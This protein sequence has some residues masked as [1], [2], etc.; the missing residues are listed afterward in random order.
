VTHT[1]R[2]LAAL[3]VVSAVGFAA[4]GDGGEKKEEAADYAWGTPER[5]DA[6]GGAREPVLAVS[7]DGSAVA[8]WI[9]WNGKIST[10]RYAPNDGW[11][12]SERIQTASEGYIN[13][14][15]PQVAIA[16]NGRAII[17]WDEHQPG[18]V[19]ASHFTPSS[20][21]SSAEQVDRGSP[22]GYGVFGSDVAMDATGNAI[23]VWQRSGSGG[24]ATVVASRYTPRNGWGPIERVD[25]DNSRDPY[26]PTV[27][28]AGNGT[29]I[30]I[31]TAFD[32]GGYIFANH[33]TPSGGWETPEA[34]D[35]ATTGA[36]SPEFLQVAMDGSGT[37]IV[38]WRQEYN[39][40]QSQLI[41]ANRYTP[42]RAWEG[43]APIE[44]RYQSYSREPH[45]SMNAQ[46]TAMVVWLRSKM[47]NQ[48]DGGIWS[49]RYT[50]SIGWGIEELVEADPF[51]L[52]D[53]YPHVAVDPN[54]NALAAWRVGSAADHIWA[55]HGTLSDGWSRSVR[56]DV[57]SGQYSF[58]QVG[59][60]DSGKGI[61]VWNE[62][63]ASSSGIFTNRYGEEPAPDHSAIWRAI[64]DATCERASACALLGGTTLAE[65]TSE[66][67]DELSRTACRPNE[68]AIDACVDELA[69]FS[70]ADF[71]MGG[72]PYVCEYVCAGNTLCEAD[73][74]ERC[75]DQ[76]DC[77][78]DTCDPADGSCAYAPADDGVSCNDGAGTCHQG[79]CMVQKQGRL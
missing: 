74:Y 78:E 29:A 60:D 14:P 17:F 37:G 69:V 57:G 25:D 61:A 65:C 6:E 70:C 20:G 32:G 51:G 64:C 47:S 22:D 44:E 38:V 68:G 26:Q 39:D 7:A 41:T 18:A 59:I 30:V 43:P 11:G 76:N 40:L 1:L 33:Y 56:L 72:R 10:N 71:E 16:Q 15:P 77:T 58:P 79:V 50:P 31:W 66:C 19:W 23:A 54:G 4:C 48:E 73:G 52:Y 21:W 45:I 49:I 53:A 5:I 42:S 9:D 36:N 8:A 34:I 35:D 28:M 24:G 46:G 67:I 55:S 62:S 3:V 75:D 63:G 27:A 13:T 12:T 2:F